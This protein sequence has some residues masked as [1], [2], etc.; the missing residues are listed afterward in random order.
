MQN[1]FFKDLIS[2]LS[3]K[4]IWEHTCPFLQMEN[5][6]SSADVNS[7]SSHRQQF[8]AQDLQHVLYDRNPVKVVYDNINETTVDCSGL[9]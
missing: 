2:G 6:S 9:K 7:P 4:I 5:T 3:V 1:I 8:T